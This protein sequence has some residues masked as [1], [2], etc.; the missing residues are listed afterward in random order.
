MS[1]RLIH[2]L[3]KTV[4]VADTDALASGKRVGSYKITGDCGAGGSVGW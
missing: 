3:G 1:T 4:F 2:P